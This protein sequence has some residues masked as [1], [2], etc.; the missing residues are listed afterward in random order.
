MISTSLSGLEASI[1][2]GR[3]M[4]EASIWV[5][6]RSGIMERETKDCDSGGMLQ[7]RTESKA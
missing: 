5:L 4:A 2:G 6:S 3:G 7:C 1:S